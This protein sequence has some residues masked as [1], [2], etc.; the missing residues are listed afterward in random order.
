M[1]IWRMTDYWA[2][3]SE[4]IPSSGDCEDYSIFK[5]VTLKQMGFDPRNMRIV[6]V[7]DI[8]RNEAHAV[9]SV[10]LNN[11]YYIMD[12]LFDDVQ[13]HSLLYQYRPYY[14]VNEYARWA[15]IPRR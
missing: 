4:F 1:Q 12:S 3:P 10:A 11:T 14:S 6:V 15:H 9:L 7:R 2:S 5:Y 8:V 13:E